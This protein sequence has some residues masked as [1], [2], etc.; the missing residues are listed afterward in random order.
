M[1]RAFFFHDPNSE[2]ESGLAHTQRASQ[3]HASPFGHLSHPLSDA[4]TAPAYKHT[5]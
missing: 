1:I 4:K 3:M 5:P 2:K